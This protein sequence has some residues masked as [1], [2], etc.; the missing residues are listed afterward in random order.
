MNAFI[1]FLEKLSASVKKIK[2]SDPGL[3][4]SIEAGLKVLKSARDYNIQLLKWQGLDIDGV[5]DHTDKINLQPKKIR[6]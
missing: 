2:K 3:A 4:K 5:S 6:V 1:S